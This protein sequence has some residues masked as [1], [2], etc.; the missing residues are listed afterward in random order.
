MGLYK[1][2]LLGTYTNITNTTIEFF[3][4]FSDE[5]GIHLTTASSLQREINVF[6]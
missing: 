6:Y 3:G 2:S 1:G 5:N 4:C